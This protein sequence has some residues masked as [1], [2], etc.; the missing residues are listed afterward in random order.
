MLTATQ[1]REDQQN[2]TPGLDEKG[3]ENSHI[4]IDGWC[5]TLSLGAF[6]VYKRRGVVSSSSLRLKQWS[7]NH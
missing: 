1:D 2:S 3:G 4:C 5:P 7:Q 6:S